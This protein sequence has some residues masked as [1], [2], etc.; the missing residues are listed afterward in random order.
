MEIISYLPAFTGIYQKC[1]LVL[2]TQ[3]QAEPQKEK[4]S[5]HLQMA[6]TQSPLCLI[7][8]RNLQGHLADEA[9]DLSF[10]GW[11]G[12]DVFFHIQNFTCSNF[13]TMLS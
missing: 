8:N 4:L 6:E 5:S 9:R 2:K 3:F 11:R 13:G 7:P 1:F 12:K 10:S